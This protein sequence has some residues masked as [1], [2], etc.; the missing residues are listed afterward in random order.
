MNPAKPSRRSGERYKIAA[1]VSF[2][3][4]TEH[5]DW[6]EGRGVTRDMSGSGLFILAY[7]V[8][9]PDSPIMVVVEIQSVAPQGKPI[10]F[11]GHG[12]VVRIQPEQGQPIG[13]AAAV[14]FDEGSG[15]ASVV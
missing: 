3:W 14:V 9:V 11:Q 4:R 7:P 5:G 6:R 13:F 12:R 1:P 2:K 10:A 8:P 15:T